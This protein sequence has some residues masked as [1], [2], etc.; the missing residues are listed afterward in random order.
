MVTRLPMRQASSDS[1]LDLAVFNAVVTDIY[2]SSLNPARWEAAL[3]NLVN[4]FA[5]PRWDNAMLIWERLTPPTGRFV[6]SSGVHAMARQGYLHAFAG[7][8][9]WSVNG[10]QLDP[11]TVV[12]SDALVPRAELKSTA[13][14]EHYLGNFS[15]DVGVLALLDRDG[16]D[17]LCLCMPGPDIGSTA[18][19]EAALRLLI[20]HIQRAV[21]ISRRIGEAELGAQ[22]ARAVLDKAPSAILMCRPDLSLT[23]ANPAAESLIRDHYLR[24]SRNR[25]VLEPAHAKRLAA[26]A[27]NGEPRCAALLLDPPGKAPVG[28][29]AIRLDGDNANSDFGPAELMIVAG[30]NHRPAID[31]VDRLRHWFDL[32]PAEARLAATLAEGG[33]LEDFASTRGIT[34]NSV[35]FLLKGVFAKTLC[36]RQAQL[37]AKLQATPI[38]WHAT[39]APAGLPSPIR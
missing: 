37:V 35:K 34:M 14:Y 31:A 3:G 4:S 38:E 6:G 2:D 19:L 8:N 10:H 26:L 32:T 5:P 16:R 33:S 13:F 12:H 36:N 24:V 17:H 15:F 25:L 11:G 27:G 22:T 20:P 7:N 9:P 1:G 30:R 18:R 39:M 28:A 21:R 29:M 23:Y